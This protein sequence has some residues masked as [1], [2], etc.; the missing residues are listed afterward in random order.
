MTAEEFAQELLDL[1]VRCCTHQG[2]NPGHAVGIVIGFGAG[3]GTSLG[4]SRDEMVAQ[5]DEGIAG[6]LE[7]P[8][9]GIPH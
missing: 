8:V 5:L 7:A 2:L 9:E 4:V 1:T 3:I 6:A